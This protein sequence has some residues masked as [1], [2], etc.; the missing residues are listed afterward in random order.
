MG[1]ISRVSSRTYRPGTRNEIMDT[2]SA[3]NT[4]TPTT[5]T[6]RPLSDFNVTLQ[7]ANKVTENAVTRKPNKKSPGTNAAQQ[8]FGLDILKG[9]NDSSS[10]NQSHYQSTNQYYGQKIRQP[11]VKFAENEP[12]VQQFNSMTL[13]K[14]QKKSTFTENRDL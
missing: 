11:K 1:L 4:T 14:D 3:S 7:N 5:A 2:K 8:Y 12:T 13:A 10:L 9:A 6:S